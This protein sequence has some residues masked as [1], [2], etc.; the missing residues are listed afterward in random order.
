MSRGEWTPPKPADCRCSYPEIVA[1]TM[2]GH[3]RDCPAHY[4]VLT[5][6]DKRLRDQETPNNG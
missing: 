5:A 1:H 4:R 6:I 2:T 3:A